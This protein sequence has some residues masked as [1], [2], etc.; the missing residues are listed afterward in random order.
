MQIKNLDLNNFRNIESLSLS[1]DPGCNIIYGENGQGKTNILESIYM[2]GFG[3]SHKNS[4][5]REIIRDGCEESHIRAEFGSVIN[6]H[7]IDIHLRKNRPKGVALDRVPIRRYGDLYGNILVVMFSSE[8]L[9]IVKRSPSDRRKFLDMQICQ[10]DPIYMDHLVN[11]NKILDQR[12]EL[13]KSMEEG[14]VHQFQDT[15][16]LWDLQLNEY[17]SRIIRKRREFIEELNEIIFEIHYDISGGKE[18]LKIVYEP[19]AREDDFYEILLKNRERDR[20][21]K[22]THAGPHRDD[23]SFY[24][25]DKDMKVYGSSGQQRSCA[26]SLKLAEI[27]IINKI[28]KEK[29]VL[30]LDDVMSELD[31]NRQTQL[32]RSLRDVQ[33]IITCTGMDEFIE[34]KLGEVRRIRIADGRMINSE[35]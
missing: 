2:C 15:L 9:D 33:T 26:L 20:Y 3:K 10:I 29:P 30:L 27:D 13:F 5:E 16:D 35:E 14:D 19:S 17:G 24:D 8:D 34:E 6:S 22:Q 11:Y 4:K 32:I 23:L 12:R 28:K 21:Y 7:R 18:K 25:Q 31:R 1:F